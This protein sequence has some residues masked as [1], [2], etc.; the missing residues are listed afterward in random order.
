MLVVLSLLVILPSF[1]N[2]RASPAS[3]RKNKCSTYTR[4]ASALFLLGSLYLLHLFSKVLSVGLFNNNF[5]LA[6]CSILFFSI[7]KKTKLNT[8]L[9]R[10]PLSLRYL[11]A[12]IAAER[13]TAK[14]IFINCFCSLSIAVREVKLSCCFKILIFHFFHFFTGY[15]KVFLPPTI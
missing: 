6:D 1:E 5:L 8:A 10:A 11:S 15:L 4:Y 12:E 14:P 2:M 9:F 3:L 13:C 7:T